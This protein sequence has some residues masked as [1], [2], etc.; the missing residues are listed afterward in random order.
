VSGEILLDKLI[1]TLIRI[2][3]EHAGAERGLLILPRGNDWRIEAEA[4]TGH[5]EITVRFLGK[6]PAPSEL[7][8]SVLKYVIRTKESVILDDAS[9]ANQFSADSYIGRKRARSV[10]CLPLVKQATL[11]GVLYLENKL[12][13]HVFTP[14]RIEVLKLLASQAAISL[15]NAGLYDDLRTENLERIRA[16]EAVRAGKARFEGILEIAE[17]AI[18]SIDA[19]QLIV[20]FNQGAEKI[21]GYTQAEII[22]S[23]LDLLLP[24]RF[25]NVHRK[26]IHE[27]AQSADVARTMGHRRE[28]SGRRK[29]GSEFP[30]EASISKLGLGGE[31]VFTVIL[32]DITERKWG[33]AFLAGEKYLLEL[34]AKGNSLVS[35]LEALCRIVEEITGGC[36]CSIL[37][38]DANGKQLRHGACPSLPTEY[39]QWVDG[40]IIAPT[41]GPCAAA[42]YSHQSIISSDLESD[43]RWPEEYRA[44][45][46]SYGLAACWS[47]PILSQ[48][49]SVLGTFALYFRKPERPTPKLQNIINQFTH[50]ASIAIE[51][52]QAEERIRQDEKELRQ[53]VEAIP[54]LVI[55][56]APDGSYLYANE[57]LLEFTGHTQED[58]V[59]GDFHE[60]IFHPD[61]VERL[62]DE[63]RQ[64]LARGLP[65]E[66]ERHMRRKDGQYRWFLTR[67]SPLQDEQGKVIRWYATGTDID[68]RKKAEERIQKENLA[69]REEIDKTSMFEEIVGASPALHSVLSRVARVAPTDSTVLITGETGTGKELIA[70]AIHK[71][72]PRS[73]RAFVSV[74]C[75]VI[76][77]SLVAS[78]LFGHEKGAFTGALQRRLGRFEL[79]EGGTIF[80]DEIGELPMETQIALLRVLQEHEFERV[81]GN[82]SLR[83]DVR[84]IAATN[85]NLQAA[86]IAG[87]FRSDLFY[88]L[89]VFPIEIPPLRE[90]KE[91]IILLIE[92]FINRYGRKAGKKIKSID[93]KALA[94]LQSY[95]WPGNIR[96]LQ[97]VIER[98]I[99]L[100]DTESF[101]VDESWLSPESASTPPASQVLAEK[102]GSH[103]K[104]IIEAALAETK[105]RVSGPSGAAAKLG[106]PASTLESKIKTLK[107]NKYRF[108]TE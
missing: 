48:M 22:G 89:N 43:D 51:R 26:H 103:E 100:C 16:E 45:A 14:A 63:R 33:E 58:V 50:L 6:S 92:Y 95:P 93:K 73:D 4:T 9:T 37:L 68:D 80:L 66:L 41:V 15:E 24:Q 25:E 64:A 83:A 31:L 13:A 78:E 88:R 34:I 76:P 40:K 97:N 47:T 101:S 28:V 71:R 72:S 99:I 98:S 106:I 49:G 54:Q 52:S 87:A 27:F 60:R 82:Q 39:A 19:D 46:L 57:R 91:D 11:I 3:L 29:D 18:I 61:D 30:A 17:D 23:P 59:A 102:L 104:E 1:D 75:A 32:R 94:L 84:V 107:I 21:F 53:I 108:K 65:F 96:E 7:P 56:L 42:A 44:L 81:G 67:F 105:G 74:N 35:V 70:R 8:D 85:R 5:D 36:V 38:V 55:V 90:R 12:T 69:L 10:L 79:A 2:A 62:R 20:L 86:S 77:S